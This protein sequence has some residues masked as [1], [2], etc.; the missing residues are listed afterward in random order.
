MTS[1]LK[2]K[3]FGHKICVDK[4]PYDKFRKGEG[5]LCQCERCRKEVFVR[6]YYSA[7]IKE[8]Q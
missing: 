3:L 4:L 5:G 7:N 1:E 6:W 8:W 2:C